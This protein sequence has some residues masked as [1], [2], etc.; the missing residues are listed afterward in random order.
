M[1]V[2]V[3]SISGIVIVK[4]VVKQMVVRKNAYKLM[5]KINLEN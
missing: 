5:E 4:T 2:I 1:L 3:L